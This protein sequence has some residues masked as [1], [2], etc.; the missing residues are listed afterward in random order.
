GV[1]FDHEE[2]DSEG[3]TNFDPR[4]EAREALRLFDLI[5]N[6]VGSSCTGARRPGRPSGPLPATVALPPG[7]PANVL[8]L[9]HDGI[10][11][12]YG[13]EGDLLQAPYTRPS[14]RYPD[15]VYLPNTNVSPR[16]SLSWDPWGDGKTK[17][18]GNWGIYYDRLFLG[19]VT[20]D[21]QPQSYAVRWDIDFS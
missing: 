4:P 7:D 21:Q 9:N 12:L 16:L 3:F 11:E 18:F 19:A 6:A 2:I 8:D 5:C 10:W 20:T 13:P 17:V 14:Q 15:S 1:R